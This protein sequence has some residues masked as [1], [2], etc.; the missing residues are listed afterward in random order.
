MRILNIGGHLLVP[1]LQR[2][3]E[4]VFS[5]GIDRNIELTINH[6][7]Y[8]T[9]LLAQVS[10]MGFQ[11]DILFYCDQGNFPLLLDPENLP[12]PS[13]WYSIDTYCNPWHIAYAH[14]FDATLVAQKDFVEF[15]TR[16]GLSAF[17]FPP[18]FLSSLLVTRTDT[19]RDVPVAF[20]GNVGHKNNPDRGPFLQAFRRLAPLVIHR[21]EFVP[22]FSRAQIVLNQTAFSEVNFRCFEAMACGAALLMEN[23]ANGLEELFGEDLILPRYPRNDAQAAA[24]IALEALAHPKALA[25]LARKGQE[26]VLTHHTDVQRAQRLVAIMTSL[27]QSPKIPQAHAEHRGSFVRAAFGMIASELGPDMENYRQFF[28]KIA[29]GQKPK[30]E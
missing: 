12:F 16:E 22:L 23:C 28:A 6:P 7:F 10:D 24:H 11:P 5:V 9:R 18:F 2:L 21:G 4:D 25:S 17:W 14:G 19:Q 20:V 27:L 8:A 3:G 26:A 1:A 13:I 30:K 29:L 15:F